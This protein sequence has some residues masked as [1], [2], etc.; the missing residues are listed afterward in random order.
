MTDRPAASSNELL[1]FPRASQQL[2]SHA[3]K[4]PHIAVVGNFPP[5]RCGIATFTADMVASL[6]KAA[7]DSEI[8]IYAMASQ[9]AD[10]CPPHLKAQ[11]VDTD[12]ES[13]RKA[14]LEIEQSDVDAVWLQHE[15]GLFGGEA[16]DWII[17]LL[18]PVAAPLIVTFHTILDNPT[19][20]QR[21]VMDWLIA[22]SSQLVVM[23]REGKAV[24]EN[25]Y[26]ANPARISIIPHG[27]PDRR[28]GRSTEMKRR[29]GLSQE[30]MLMT[31]GLLS[32]GKGLE[33][34]ISALPEIIERH[35]DTHY[36]IAG[37][38]HPKLVEAE[39]EAYRESLVNLAEQLGVA[40][41]I[42]WV[43]RYLP[44]D[45]LLDLIEAADI[46]LTP[47][48][49]AA[50]STS[51]TLSYAAALGKAII[52]TPYKHA[53]E[54]LDQDVG[55]LVPFGDTQAVAKAV[56]SLLDDRTLMESFQKKAYL[57]GREMTWEAFGAKSIA[58]IDQVKSSPARYRAV[59]ALG[60]DALLDMCDDTGMLQHGV[61]TIADR[62]HGYCIDDN[63]RA[64]MLAAAS[65]LP[66][67]RHAPVFAAFVQHGWNPDLRRFRNFMGYDR[68]WLEDV[69][70]DDSCGRTLWALGVTCRTASDPGLRLWAKKL[71]SETANM[72]LEF[73]SPRAVAF[74]VLGADAVLDSE[75]HDETAH[76]TVAH[77]ATVLTRLYS[78]NRRTGWHWFEPYLAYDNCRLPEAMLKASIR[79]EDRHNEGLAL[80]ALEWIVEKQ[81]APA[82]HFRPVGSMAFG[83]TDR[84]GSPFDQQAVDAWAAV[85]A[86]VTA[87]RHTS[88]MKW[89]SAAR[90]AFAWFFG[91]NDRGL[92]LA[93]AKTGSC[94]DGLTP[95]G[96]NQ[97]QGAES[98]LS[99]HMA[100]RNMHQLEL[101]LRERHGTQT[102]EFKPA[103]A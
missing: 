72:A 103:L 27:V 19:G 78:S 5:T 35:P 97:N 12:I 52:S 33:L 86:T 43:N 16:G 1:F 39:G 38:T 73:S 36:C 64:L 20:A 100:H 53:A 17:E 7:P 46:Y 28:F 49:N 98:L 14:G 87:F 62:A 13:Y 37:V 89:L 59:A 65:A 71:W 83:V 11:I 55:L 44:T 25:V 84:R 9:Q 15:F 23:S 60:Q 24:L 51:G 4:K 32:P 21:H 80:E 75:P 101:H 66:F 58:L 88:D 102:N 29:L 18:E 41:R 96:V 42:S 90:A 54:L 93:D 31:F 79:L 48:Q 74:A 6:R 57:A 26:H 95:Q 77:G 40:D 68:R 34:V 3:R 8:D 67:S 50:Q 45:E 47:Y 82:G 61:F 10:S 81:T 70:S 2:Q 63:A 99:L 22:R 76:A 92:S 56:I 85:D 94:Q 91:S 69:G 30:N